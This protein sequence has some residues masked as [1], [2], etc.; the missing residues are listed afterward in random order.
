[1]H[2]RHQSLG[3]ENG[4]KRQG[5]RHKGQRKDGE[6]REGPSVRV[7]EP[8]RGV[9]ER[10]RAG[11]VVKSERGTRVRE[12]HAV[13][14][15]PHQRMRDG[16]VV[17]SE[18]ETRVRERHAVRAKPHERLREGLVDK[19]GPKPKRFREGIRTRIDVA[20]NEADGRRALKS[21]DQPDLEDAS[22][23]KDAS[24]SGIRK[25]MGE[26]VETHIRDPFTAKL[27]S[28]WAK[29]HI[30]ARRVQ[31]YAETAMSIA[32]EGIQ[33]LEN[34]A[35]AGDPKHAHQALMKLF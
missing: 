21:E 2:L 7:R 26:K 31:E 9:R 14:E 6:L 1:M 11:P 30:N 27:R 17:K 4:C 15:E 13:G 18:R 29:G 5:A 10:M 28:D 3:F 34:V 20:S 23:S 19:D 35:A 24:H 22:H 8:H 25:R 33:S 16:S 12:G 32:R